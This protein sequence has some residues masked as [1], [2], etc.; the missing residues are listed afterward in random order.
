MELDELKSQIQKLTQENED[1]KAKLKKY[2]T[3]PSYKKYYQD[4]K[5][6]VKESQR[7]YREKLLAE[8]PDRLKEYT[9]RANKKYQDKKKLEKQLEQEDK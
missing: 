3:N 7:K 4:H 6:A 9:R 8:D 1:L 2:T 5:E